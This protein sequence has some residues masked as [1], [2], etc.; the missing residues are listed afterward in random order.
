M[1]LSFLTKNDIPTA[2]VSI[3]KLQNVIETGKC[4]IPLYVIP[5]GNTEIRFFLKQVR[6][7]IK[8]PH[9]LSFDCE[10]YLSILNADLL[11]ILVHAIV[12]KFTVQYTSRALRHY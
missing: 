10:H 4:N 3:R 2:G 9:V 5:S 1:L 12:S 11:L 7:W 6:Y 8:Q